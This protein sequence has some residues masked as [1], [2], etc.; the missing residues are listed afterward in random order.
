MIMHVS[1]VWIATLTRHGPDHPRW[2][3]VQTVVVHCGLQLTKLRGPPCISWVKALEVFGYFTAIFVPKNKINRK[4]VHPFGRK[5]LKM[6]FSSAKNENKIQ[7]AS[8]LGIYVFW[9]HHWLWA[10]QKSVCLSV[11]CWWWWQVA[12]CVA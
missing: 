9:F 5:I 1:S 8:G 11:C 2:C 4:Y 6:H 10:H 3:R 7:S 12:G